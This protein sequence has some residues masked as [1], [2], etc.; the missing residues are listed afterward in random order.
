MRK[1]IKSLEDEPKDMYNKLLRDNDIQDPNSI[2]NEDW[3]D[4]VS[5]WPL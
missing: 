1:D 3:I 4:D 2:S 5:L